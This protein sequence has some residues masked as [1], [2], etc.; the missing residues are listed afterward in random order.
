MVEREVDKHLLQNV[1]RSGHP[2]G[3]TSYNGNKQEG[4]LKSL[5]LVSGRVPWEV[6]K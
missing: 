3:S 4:A 1:V 2:G 5:R 6:L